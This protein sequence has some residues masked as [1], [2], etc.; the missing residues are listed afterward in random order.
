MNVDIAEGKWKQFKADVR[1]KWGELTDGDVDQIGGKKDKF[2]GK[3][4]EKY[5]KTK[6]EA[7]EAFEEL[8]AKFN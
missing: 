1:T 5:G 7:E 2:V 6:E 4:Q 8:K 3:L